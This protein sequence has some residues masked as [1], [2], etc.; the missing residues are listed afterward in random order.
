[1]TT[2]V[3]QTASHFR[4]EVSTLSRE[5]RKARERDQVRGIL[6]ETTDPQERER[7][8]E[9]RTGKRKSAFYSR[10]REVESGEFDV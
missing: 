2:R 5:E 7:I 4:H 8:W 6:K 1:V 9:K 3:Q 10:K